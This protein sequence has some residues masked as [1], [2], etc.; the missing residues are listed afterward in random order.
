MKDIFKIFTIFTP[1]QQR[2]CGFIVFYMMIG[3]ILEA[4]GIGAILPLISIMGDERFLDKH[5][6]V[7]QYIEILG[8]TAH[9]SFIIFS[10]VSLIILYILKNLYMAWLTNLQIK[11]STQNQVVYAEGLLAGYLNKPYLY[12]LEQNSATLLRNV[13]SAPIAIF[14]G[15]L[16]PTFTLL[17]EVITA[18]TIWSMLI[19]VDAFTAIIVA[20]VLGGMMYAILRI[21]RG[22][23]S[24][25]GEIQ[26]EYSI[27]Y[28]KWLN[29]GLGSIKETKVLRK[30]KY[31]LDKFSNGYRKYGQANG[32]FNFMN[33]L[34]RMFIETMVTSALLIL[35]IVKLIMGIQPSEIVP[36]LG[37]LALAAFRLMP[38]ANRIVN[39]S[40]GIKF[41]MPL[42]NL[43]YDELM[44][45]RE[46]KMLQQEIKMDMKKGKLVFN[47]E[48][49]VEKL[50][51]KYSQ[52]KKEV[53][54]QI[55][56]SIPKGCFVGIIG[57]SGAGKTTF[58]DIMLGL[59]NPSKGKI[60]VDDV[61]IFENIRAWQ[62]HLSYV[63]Q[64]IYLVDGTI[65]ENIALG[66][67]ENVI[68]DAKINRVLQMAELHD[69]IEDLPNK[70]YTHVGE[71]GVK[72]SGGQRQRIGIAR[73]LY[74]EPEVL[75]LDEATSALDSVTEKSIT[76]T[77]LKL[78]GQI[79]IVAIAHRIS[80]LKDCDFKI[81]FNEGKAEVLSRVECK[82]V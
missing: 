57:Q 66:V 10:S 12:H 49:K 71:R 48:I 19:F 82:D 16:I 50:T 21:F 3:S 58:V 45:I 54:K 36:L 68:D 25:R 70:M 9:T 76:D 31:F 35:I 38:C 77:I 46:K 52:G 30:E 34:P 8:I 22:R 27:I 13:S 20:G 60:L 6:V 73:A 69:F 41:Q 75:I 62:E 42:F 4:V 24:R 7:K 37:V 61:D 14:T 26:N 23:I 56:F 65:R 78:K 1:K 43:L 44:E 81:K 51:F 72:L 59:L 55:S 15:I 63:P 28:M 29:Q 11:F 53:L 5:I 80:T 40:N 32:D 39:L 79:T 67:P 64:N 18:V 33:Q 2:Y 47:K 17:T 74:Y